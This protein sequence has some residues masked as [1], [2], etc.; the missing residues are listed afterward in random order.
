MQI[1]ADQARGFL[2]VGVEN[3]LQNQISS[4][5]PLITLRKGQPGREGA[6]RGAERKAEQ[7]HQGENRRWTMLKRGVEWRRIDGRKRAED[8]GSGHRED[9]NCPL[10]RDTWRVI[11][12]GINGEQPVI[13]TAIIGMMILFGHLTFDAIR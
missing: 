10:G 8:F 7:I 1:A 4:C 5:S 6:F 3:R 13:R 12:Q 9:V 2:V 11:H